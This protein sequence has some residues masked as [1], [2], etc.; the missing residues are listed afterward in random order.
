MSAPDIAVLDSSADTQVR[1]CR[2]LRELGLKAVPFDRLDDLLAALGEGRRFDMLVLAFDSDTGRSLAGVQQGGPFADVDAPIMLL[3]DPGQ[4]DLV[5]SVMGSERNDFMLLPFGDH[6]LR[7]RMRSL[8]SRWGRPT[9]LGQTPPSP[10]EDSGAF[11]YIGRDAMASSPDSTVTYKSGQSQAPTMRTRVALLE[12]S[13]EEAAAVQNL[14][15]QSGYD[16]VHQS[17]GKDF[18]DM[19][20]RDTFDVLMLDWNVPDLSGYEV[21]LRVRGELQSNVLVLMLTARD[22][23]FEVVQALNGGADDYLTKPWRPFELLARINALVRRPGQQGTMSLPDEIEGWHFDNVL[24]VISHDGKQTAKLTPK[25]FDVARLLF[26]HLGRPLSREHLKN[27]VWAEEVNL[28]TIDT[29]VSRVRTRL[30]L[31]VE[32]GFQLQAIYGFGYRLDRVSPTS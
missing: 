9:K 28:R 17:N 20:R 7:E 11:R 15:G 5:A 27:S 32:H 30:E 25:E 23:E 31:T 21:L 12:D 4:V 1:T 3:L 2:L 14:L 16:V 13:P 24:K 26:R 22:G 29:H 19:L 18:L 6:E 10:G 8:Y